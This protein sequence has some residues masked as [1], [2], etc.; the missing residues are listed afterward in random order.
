[1]INI[2]N[3]ISLKRI[4]SSNRKYHQEYR[5]ENI[6]VLV[7]FLSLDNRWRNMKISRLTAGKKEAFGSVHIAR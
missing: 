7:F 1:M 3:I 4:K 6:I 2:G 5:I